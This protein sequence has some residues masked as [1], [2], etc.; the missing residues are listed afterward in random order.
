MRIKANDTPVGR[1]T[2]KPGKPFAEWVATGLGAGYLPVAPGTWGS[3]EGAALAWLIH[4]WVP[5]RGALV[6][7]LAAAFFSATGV[8]AAAKTARYA[9]D[10]DPSKV[11]IDEIAGQ[12]LTLAWVPLTAASLALGFLLFRVFDI[13]KPFPARQSEDLPGGWGIMADDLIAGVF[14]GVCLLLLHR[15]LGW[16]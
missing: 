10:P 1:P 12:L 9:N 8:W 13:V 11:V 4:L 6:I 16:I 14:S 5:Q 7:G 15:W 3:L 2:L